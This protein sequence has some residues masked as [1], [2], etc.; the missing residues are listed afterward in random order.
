MKKPSP[1]PIRAITLSILLFSALSFLAC[2]QTRQ[3]APGPAAP[4]PEKVFVIFEGPWA[5]APDPKDAGKILLIAPKTKIHRDLYVAASNGTTLSAGVYDLSVPVSG[6]PGTPTTAP[7]MAQAKTT[8]ADLQRVLESKS[9]RYVIRLPKP[10]AYLSAS[11]FR[12]R[13]G[14]TYPPDPSTE[15]DYVTSVSLRYSVT[16]LNGFSLS[17]TPDSGS[18]NPQLLQVETPTISFN[19]DPAEYVD[20]SEKCHVHS[21][22]S[23]RDLSRLLKLTLYIDFPDSPSSCHDTD[24]QKSKTAQN[25]P[26]SQLARLLGIL[27]G[28]PAM[29]Q[30]AALMPEVALIRQP[31][32]ASLFFARTPVMCTAAIIILNVG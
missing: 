31:A 16:S 1:F 21:R 18:F 7:D 2:E 10:E 24:P 13:V 27:P 32:V 12:S 4:P 19:I 17:G 14:P 8:A 5:V 22:E 6:T 11:R 9:V 25:V 3:T 15:K 20:P 30:L 26:A 28:H 29:V 23:F